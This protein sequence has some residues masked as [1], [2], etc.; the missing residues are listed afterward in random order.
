MITYTE[1]QPHPTS[2]SAC[3]LRWVLANG[4][5]AI[6][7]EIDA[8]PDRSF[9]LRVVPFSA[10]GSAFVEHFQT[11]TSA[12]ARHADIARQLRAAGWDTTDRLTVRRIA[13]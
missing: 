3:M 12:M 9:D 5:A 11:A 1:L 8:N 13:S 7:C 2:S 10:P 6:A 4:S